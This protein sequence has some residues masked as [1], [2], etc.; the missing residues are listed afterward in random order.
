[1]NTLVLS[2]TVADQLAIQQLVHRFEN[3]FDAGDLDSH[4]TTWADDMS[5]ESSFGNHSDRDSYRAWVASFIEQTKAMG[6]TRHLINNCEIEVRGDEATMFCYLTI[7]N[8]QKRSII[9]T[10]TC[11][12][13]LRRIDGQWK[14]TRRVLQVDQ[15]LSVLAEG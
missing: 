3:T 1:M 2:D 6:G 10:T 5:F 13:S 11:Q 7:L 12:D 4:M 15:D 14:F 8:R 9:A